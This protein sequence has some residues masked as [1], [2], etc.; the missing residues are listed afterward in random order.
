MTPAAPSS[1]RPE[2]ALIVQSLISNEMDLR[3]HEPVWKQTTAD[4][5]LDSRNGEATGEMQ[6]RVPPS[7]KEKMQ[8]NT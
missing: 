4:P 2:I 3:E 1:Y 7:S 5:I 8:E 6:A